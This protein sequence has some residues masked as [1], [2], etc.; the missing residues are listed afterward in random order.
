MSRI[1][2][3]LDELKAAIA[4]IEGRTND[5]K[6]ILEVEDNKLKFVAIDRYDNPMEI[7]LF[8]DGNMNAQFRYT[9]RLM[10]MKDKKRI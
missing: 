4:E 5:L 8:Q 1:N 9:E 3:Q 10:H 6:V 2:I 7:V